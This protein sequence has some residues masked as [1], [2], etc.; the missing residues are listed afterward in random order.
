MM[1]AMKNKLV[2]IGNSIVNGFP[3][4]R[5]RSFPGLIRAAIDGGRT[6]FRA[7]VINKGANGNTTD[8]LL[9]R[10]DH[11]AIDHH[12]AA[13]FIMTGTNDFIY[14]TGDPERTFANLEI[15]AGKADA[16][17]IIPVH[18]TPLSVDAPL[19]ERKWMAGSGIDYLQVN[20][21]IDE[22][23]EIIRKSGR[24][25]IDTNIAY[26]QY[27]L[28]LEDGPN[29][30]KVPYAYRDGVHPTEQ[31]YEYIAKNV[32]EWIENNADKIKLK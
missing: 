22:L 27:A 3:F 25:F 2:F 15:M 18:M 24:L 31:G 14:R 4:S 12:P 21:Q 5:G 17:G 6:G 16:A 29:P 30:L 19:A 7:D 10:F 32:I 20:R 28:A 9:L 23:S 26:R 11:D 13:V 8:E 1:Y